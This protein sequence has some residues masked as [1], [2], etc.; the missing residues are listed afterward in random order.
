M[1]QTQWG[2]ACWAPPVHSLPV[3]NYRLVSV[4]H[5]ATQEAGRD[6]YDGPTRE[7]RE[8]SAHRLEGEGGKGLKV[9]A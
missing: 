6:A 4:G 7:S 1:H 9:V 3:D 5:W 8:A 2:P